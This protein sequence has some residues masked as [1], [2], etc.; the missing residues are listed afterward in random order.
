MRLPPVVLLKTGG[1][2]PALLACILLPLGLGSTLVFTDSDRYGAPVFDN[3]KILTGGLPWFEPM[4]WWGL[5]MLGGV[6]TM[7]TGVLLGHLRFLHFGLA[8]GVGFWAFWALQYLS[9]GLTRPE[10]SLGE[11]WAYGAIALFYYAIAHGVIKA[12]GR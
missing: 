10:A 3:A 12:P 7:T 9:A 8:V 11:F 2:G 1:L 6:I 5:L 4:A